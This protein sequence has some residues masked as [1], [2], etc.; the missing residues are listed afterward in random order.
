[1]LV[2]TDTTPINYLILIGHVD[3]L[4]VLFGGVVVPQAVAD[5]LLHPHT[6][7]P[8]R[9]W[10]ATPPAWCVIESPRGPLDP[11]LAYLG[12]GEREAIALCQGLGV[13]ALLTDDT[14]ARREA[15]ARGIEVIRTLDLLERASLRGLLDLPTVL[16]RLQETTFYAPAHIIDAMLVRHRQRLSPRQPPSPEP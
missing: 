12:E 4:P 3:V 7:E 10:I 13:A 16:A 9:Q 6:P 15:R 8:V 14:Q 11:T 5:E 1:M 2:V